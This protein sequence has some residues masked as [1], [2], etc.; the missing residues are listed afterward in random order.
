MGVIVRL[1]LAVVLAYGIAAASYLAL[2]LPGRFGR[3][4]V[5]AVCCPVLFSPLLLPPD[6][7]LF[8]SFA[9]VAAVVL[10]LKLHDLQLDSQRGSR[11][12]LGSFAS[13]L[14]NP[15]LLV[16]R[17]LANEPRP[18][19]SESFRRLGWGVLGVV[20][21]SILLIGVFNVDWD[22]YPFL[23][24]HVSKV[25]AFYIALLSGLGAV[26]ALWRLL[27]GVAREPM[28]NPY[29]ARTPADFWRRY[30]RPMQQFFQEDFFKLVGGLR[31]PVRATLLVFALSAFLHEY[32]FG[33]ALGRVQGY[34]TAF[35]LLQG[36]AV[37]ATARVKVRGWR[38]VPWTVGTLGFNLVS[39]VLFFASM[40][41]LM[42]FYSG[43]LPAWL[44]GW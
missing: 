31:T 30:N 2:L 4:I 38:A 11:L 25:T 7:P 40:N 20:V 24:E 32:I 1:A 34:Q 28:D 41:G 33:I 39:S 27:G 9:A 22:R 18:A 13:F 5:L 16:R 29:L 35:F 14:G 12:S 43:G 8:R 17:R 19:A 42:P 36:V 6:R 15:F 23:V 26:T 10:V 37:V 21:G 3:G 44:R